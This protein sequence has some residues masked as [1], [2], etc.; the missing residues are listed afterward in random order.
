MHKCAY[1][2]SRLLLLLFLASDSRAEITFWQMGGADLAWTGND[3]AS[4]LV[5]FDA[6]PT[7]LQPVYLTPDR[8][9]FSFLDNWSDFKQPPELDYFDGQRPRA[10]RRWNSDIRNGYRG[11]LLVDGDSTTYNPP[12]S[13]YG[14]LEWYTIDLAVPVP[15][16]RFG[17]YTPSQGFRSDG[18]PLKDDAVPAY[19]VSISAETNE[20]V[21]QSGP[22]QPVGRVVASV[23]E[24]FSTNV[25]I[26]FPRQYVRVI[27]YQRKTSGLDL[28]NVITAELGSGQ[29]PRGAL[30]DFE[31]FGEGVPQRAF[32]LSKILEL[33]EE[34][35]FGDLHW[36]TTPM[37]VSD[38][39]AIEDPTAPASLQIEVRTGRDDNPNVYHEFTDKGRERVVSRDRYEKELK[40]PSTSG[41]Q[42]QEGRP[43]VQASIR[44]DTDHWTYW[45]PPITR[46]GQPLGL[47]SGSF[48]QLKLIF[49]SDSFDSFVRLDSLWIE[50]APR[51]ARRVIGEVA[52]LDQLRPEGGFTEVALGEETDFV[53]HLVADFDGID[54]PGFDAVRIHTGHHMR[55]VGLEMGEPLRA[56]DPIDISEGER[57]LAVFLPQRIE[58]GNALP[59]RVLFNTKIFTYASTFEG[60]VFDATE[61]TLPQPI[62]AGDASAELNTSSLRVLGT[63]R[64]TAPLQHLS[65]S[66]PVITPNGDSTN[67]E[68]AI[69]Y[70]LFR[71]PESVPVEL[72][73]YSLDGHLLTTRQVGEQASGQQRITWDGRDERGAPLPPG[74][75]LIKIALHSEA[76]DPGR[77]L[78]VGI[79]Y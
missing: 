39:V 2:A 49:H 52:R 32:Y 23:L 13:A 29:A 56:V 67:D 38:G 30:G 70:T 35:N 27:R 44:Y 22:D 45:S 77:L 9:V 69:S 3:T 11:T 78:P 57:S 75:Y 40:P 21:T 12:S 62:E 43:G 33:G 19:E 17:F 76:N 47:A 66:T 63:S 58:P 7:A 61:E 8:S 79:A 6:H 72:R 73:V 71:L 14:T 25:Q 16:F 74:L 5:D 68:V 28:L 15:A 31:L 4:V 55:F 34:L 1:L 36:Q 60:T 50:R 53:Y 20:A 59:V 18:L 41:G 51:L 65:L 42:T 64:D 54:A 37:R 46:T 26:E 10:W 48:I 24:N